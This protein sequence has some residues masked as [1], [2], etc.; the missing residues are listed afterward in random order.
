MAIAVNQLRLLL[1]RHPGRAF[2]GAERNLKPD[3]IDGIVADVAGE[4]SRTGSLAMPVMKSAVVR[5]S[6]ASARASLSDTP[7]ASL[8]EVLAATAAR[9]AGD[10]LVEVLVGE[11]HADIEFSRLRQQRLQIFVEIFR[12]LV[13]DQEGRI[14][15]V[16]RNGDALEGGAR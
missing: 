11:Q 5:M 16:G 6:G 4:L 9:R 14:A 1:G 15:P 3:G 7:P 12:G 10:E 8:I 2:K 13:D